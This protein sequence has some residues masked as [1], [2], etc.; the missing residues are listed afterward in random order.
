MIRRKI[1]I[2]KAYESLAIILVI[3]IGLSSISLPATSGEYL[4][5]TNY[6][7]NE[8][9][10][11][12]KD[13]NYIDTDFVR[14]DFVFGNPHNQNGLKGSRKTPYSQN[15]VQ[16]ITQGILYSSEIPKEDAIEFEMQLAEI[17]EQ[18]KNEKK[19]TRI[20]EL[21]EMALDLYANYN[22]LPEC[23][24]YENVTEFMEQIF[25]SLILAFF[26]TENGERELYQELQI[27]HKTANNSKKIQSLN[28]GFIGSLLSYFTFLGS[29]NPF[30]ITFT[31]GFGFNPEPIV[32]LT[33]IDIKMN[34]T[35]IF[36]DADRLPEEDQPGRKFWERFDNISILINGPIWKFL[37]RGAEE[38]AFRNFKLAHITTF[39]YP[40]YLLWGNAISNG[41]F[42][43]PHFDGTN[44][45]MGLIDTFKGNFFF[46]GVPW[47][48]P[49]SF[50]LY[51]TW[52]E[53]WTTNLEFGIIAN[54]GISIL[55]VP[56]RPYNLLQELFS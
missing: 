21:T 24:T 54:A 35:G 10:D 49:I 1:I 14:Y 38:D 55:F 17:Q 47:T 28:I 40:F 26:E 43:S 13:Q 29:V 3:S 44:G 20:K 45:D 53:P 33:F 56:A 39:Y 6:L 11:N 36:V 4:L 22:I 50:T 41:L 7:T 8:I 52:P 42:F 34:K 5:E 30:G 51:T 19:P 37:W 16:D 15:S 23:F 9:E 48:I 27:P 25:T 32:N 31:D 12:L 46:L 18:I 2:N